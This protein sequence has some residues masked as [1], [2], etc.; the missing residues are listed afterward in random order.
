MSV[1]TR[2]RH[3]RRRGSSGGGRRTQEERRSQTQARLLE[4]TMDCLV[5]LG[6]SGTSTTEVARRAGV[7]RGAQQHHYPTKMVLVAASLEHLLEAQRLAYESAFAVLPAGRRNVEGALDL[8]W[9][10][11]R[12]PPAKALM[13]LAVAARTDEELRPLCRDLNERILQVITETFERMFPENELAPDFVPTLLRG[14]FAMFVG[15]SVQNALDDDASG[16]QEAVLRQVKDFARLIVPQPGTPTAASP[17]PTTDT[18]STPPGDAAPTSVTS[19]AC[20]RGA[21]ATAPPS[22]AATSE[23]ASEPA[24]PLGKAPVAEFRAPDAPAATYT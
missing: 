13:E 1:S 11:F 2:R 10:V 24:S 4:A 9:E 3:P 8:L 5:H 15:L 17:P 20:T 21:A 6:W 18:G 22:S 23:P 16:H 7:S 19:T 14:L 12:G